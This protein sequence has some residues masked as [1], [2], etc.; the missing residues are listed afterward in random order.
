MVIKITVSQSDLHCVP[1]D[2]ETDLSREREREKLRGA[3]EKQEK[4]R[5]EEETMRS[6][7]MHSDLVFY[8]ELLRNEI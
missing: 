8:S 5:E 3:E 1:T 4:N 2:R 6:A 7:E